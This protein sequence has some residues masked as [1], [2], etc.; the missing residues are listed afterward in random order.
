MANTE[1]LTDIKE[2]I[3]DIERKEKLT[4]HKFLNQFFK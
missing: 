4:S 1:L 3:S 2:L